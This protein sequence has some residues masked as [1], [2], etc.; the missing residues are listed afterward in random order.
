MDVYGV[1]VV[2]QDSTTLVGST[3]QHRA[4]ISESISVV[5]EKAWGNLS[6]PSEQ[7]QTS[8]ARQSQQT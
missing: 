8:R 3:A 1:L 5:Y 7:D 6:S 4:A 2:A